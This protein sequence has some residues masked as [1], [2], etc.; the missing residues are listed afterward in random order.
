MQQPTESLGLTSEKLALVV[1]V[2]VAEIRANLFFE[3]IKFSLVQD[4]FDDGIAIVPY[5]FRNIM[6]LRHLLL[7]DGDNIWIEY[8]RE[9]IALS[10]DEPFLG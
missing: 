8:Y 9:S 1:R 5:L 4:T 7:L 3:N 2:R 10:Q 6:M